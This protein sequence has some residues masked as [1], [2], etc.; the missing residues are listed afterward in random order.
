MAPIKAC[1]VG[2]G[3]GGLAFHVP[4]VLALPDLFTLHA[5]MERN[6]AGPGGKVQERFGEKAMQGTIIHRTFEDVLADAQVELVIITTPSETHYELAKRALEAGK[7]VLVDKPL[8]P[9][10]KEIL[11][12]GRIATNKN[13]V[14][15]S[16]QNRRWDSDFLA[17]R[18]L[19]S[20][21]ADD[22][23][24]LGTLYEF[25]SRFDRFRLDLKGTWKD[26]PLPGNGLAFDLASHTIDQVIQLFG[27]P[28]SITAMIENIRGIGSPEVDDSFTIY[29][30]YP[31]LPAASGIQPTSLTAILRGH[32]LSVRS[33]QVRYVARGTHGTFQKFGVDVQ[34]DQLRAVADPAGIAAD[35]AF[36]VEP[37]AI[38]GT[39][40]NVAGDGTVV[41]SSWP[42]A[43]PGK[44]IELFKN[45]A[46]VIRDGAEPAVRWTESAEVIEMIELAHQSARE[47]RTVD[48]P[49]SLA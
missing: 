5:V 44:Y 3:L 36:G 37:E 26:L 39:V 34:E 45:L 40:Q 32:I 4:F 23:K 35:T 19:L 41:E 27:R 7:H 46:A 6:P 48:V 42:S 24:S 22:P 30:H 25:E 43:E 11:E 12:L 20:L 18:K 29:L 16:F 17:F 10:K 8:S 38:W 15:Y 13:V 21:P 28:K 14:L 9:T 49:P 1:V 31:P 47:R 33:P 2:L